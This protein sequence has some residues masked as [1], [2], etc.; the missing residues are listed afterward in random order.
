MRWD[1]GHCTRTSGSF[2]PRWGLLRRPRGAHTQRHVSETFS[3]CPEAQPPHPE[4][5]GLPEPQI[6]VNSAPSLAFSPPTFSVSRQV[7]FS[8]VAQSCPTL[9]DPMDCSTPGFPVHHQLVELAQT[10][11]LQV[12]DTIKSSHPLLSPSP[13]AFHLSQHQGLFK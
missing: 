8:S 7:Q 5:S 2:L 4:Q 11:I 13:S 9:C 10:H 1:I 3:I 6:S 12:S